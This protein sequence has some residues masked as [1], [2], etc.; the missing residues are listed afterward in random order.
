MSNINSLFQAAK[1]AED[2]GGGDELTH[3]DVESGTELTALVKWAK[4][5]TS[6][7]GNPGIRFRLQVTE[8]DHKGATVWD[9]VY[10]STKPG[11]GPASFNKRN[12]A[13]IGA[14]G[15]D[16]NFLSTNPSFDAIAKAI[17]EQTVTVR[18]KWQD[19]SDD[20]RVFGEHSWKAAATGYVP[21][22]AAA[23]AAGGEAP[24]G[25]GAAPTGF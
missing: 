2:N 20:G 15:I 25:W 16:E 13:K 17:V 7:A 5:V 21:G 9:A 19:P 22:Q 11:D 12:F 23:P 1:N 10:F 3:T 6:K 14:A 18:I 4:A 24:A 8:G